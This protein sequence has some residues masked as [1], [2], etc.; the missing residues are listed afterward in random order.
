MRPVRGEHPDLPDELQERLEAD[1]RAGELDSAMQSGSDDT[2]EIAI[3]TR[4]AGELTPEEALRALAAAVPPPTP[5]P[6][7][8]STSPAPAGECLAAPEGES[9]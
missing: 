2:P 6:E 3:G 7:R 4:F 5:H 8:S 9:E 1:R